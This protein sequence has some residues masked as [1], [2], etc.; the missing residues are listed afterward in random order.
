MGAQRF[1]SGSR[2]SG[3]ARRLGFPWRIP[4]HAAEACPTDAGLAE[5]AGAGRFGAN[6]LIV[7]RGRW[8]PVGDARSSGVAAN[9]PAGLVCLVNGRYLAAADRRSER[10][11]LFLCAR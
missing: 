5:I 2:E 1:P 10:A 8:Q 3:S 4:L 7:I 6:S 11:I 9:G